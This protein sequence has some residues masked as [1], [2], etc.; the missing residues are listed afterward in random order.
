MKAVCI[1]APD[2]AV[3]DRK[4]YSRHEVRLRQNRDRLT[5]RALVWIAVEA[6]QSAEFADALGYFLFVLTKPRRHLSCQ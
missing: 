1:H 4:S 5:T 3:K 2:Q 6:K